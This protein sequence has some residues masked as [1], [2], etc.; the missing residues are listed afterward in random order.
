MSQ[1]ILKLC[2]TIDA[3]SDEIYLAIISSFTP[4][5]FLSKGAKRAL[6]PSLEAVEEKASPVRE[7]M[8]ST[9][10]WGRHSRNFEVFVENRGHVK[11]RAK[12]R[13]V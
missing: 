11:C 3:E 2:T 9:T 13:E 1:N 7:A 4:C 10:K 12:S 6:N 8:P 5:I